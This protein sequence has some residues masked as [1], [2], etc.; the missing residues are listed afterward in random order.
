MALWGDCMAFLDDT[1]FFF[2]DLYSVPQFVKFSD[3]NDRRC[4]NINFFL[5][6]FDTNFSKKCLSLHYLKIST[7]NFNAESPFS[8]FDEILFT[9]SL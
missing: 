3:K 7:M 1:G 8:N 6:K 2:T 4:H 9:P 5:M